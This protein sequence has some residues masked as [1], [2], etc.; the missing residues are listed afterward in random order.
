MAEFLITTQSLS[1]TTF[2]YQEYSLD[3]TSLITSNDVDV[4]FNPEVDYIEYYVFSL[5]NNIFFENTE[6]FPRYKL[7]DNQVS[8][9]PIE[10][11]RSTGFQQGSYNTLYNFLKRRLSSNPFSTYYIDEISSDRTEIRLNTMYFTK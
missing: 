7:I 8:I 10:D 6:G 4:S 3:D 5:N 9:D 11:L 1:P 2:E